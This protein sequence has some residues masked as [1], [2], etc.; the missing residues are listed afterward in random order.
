MRTKRKLKPNPEPEG[1]LNKKQ[2]ARYFGTAV[3][4]IDLYMRQG[5]IPFVKLPGGHLVRFRLSEVEKALKHFPVAQPDKAA[6]TK[7]E[8][9]EALATTDP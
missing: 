7:K 1:L 8:A 2:I 3:F 6:A 5:L 9:E 4:T